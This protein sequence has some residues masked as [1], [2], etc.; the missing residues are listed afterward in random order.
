MGDHQRLVGR[1]HL[2]CG[3]MRQLEHVLAVLPGAGLVWTLEEFQG[4]GPAPRGLSVP[5]FEQMADD[6]FRF[7]SW[8]ELTSF[9]AGLDQTIWCRLVGTQP[10]GSEPE[11]VVIAFDSSEWEVLVRPQ[12]AGPVRALLA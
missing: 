8:D 11:V 9:A 10:G 4:I 6:G 12:H 3:G 5:E 1:M 7:E 2:P